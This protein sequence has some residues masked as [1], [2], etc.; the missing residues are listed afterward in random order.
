MKNINIY[1]LTALIP[2]LSACGYYNP[3]VADSSCKP[4]SINRVLWTNSTG[5]MGL[6]MIM[7][8]SL[9][10]WLRK[11]SLIHLVD[12]PKK[13][14]YQLTGRLVSVD[15]PDLS[16]GSHGVASE[17]RA[18]LK[19]DFAITDNAAGKKIW[20]KTNYTFTE[21]LAMSSNPIQLQANKKAALI[22]IAND[23]GEMIYLHII[24]NI[25]RSK[26]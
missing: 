25:M 23:I 11:S 19:V 7:F 21:T 6:E 24:N 10:S 22:K 26:E 17:L 8:Q 12:D 16:Y 9:S 14:G 3:Y 4:I 5:E 13:A 15:Y 2:L 20:E 18:N 1:I